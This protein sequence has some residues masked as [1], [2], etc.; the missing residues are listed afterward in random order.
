M[1]VYCVM[2]NV[3]C[4]M[5]IGH[6]RIIFNGKR[7]Q[8]N[9]DNIYDLFNESCKKCNFLTGLI[10]CNMEFEIYSGEHETIG[11]KS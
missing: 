8:S 5:F 2:D 6:V 9:A 4:I 11:T 1:C 7:T 10:I 3:Y